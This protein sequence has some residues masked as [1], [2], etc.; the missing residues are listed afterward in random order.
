[1]NARFIALAAALGA[2]IAAHAQTPGPRQVRDM[3]AAC[4]I[5]HGTNG[6]A[7]GG[8]KSR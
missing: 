7:P 2:A 8:Q 5:C 1:M 6:Q 4:A 3:A